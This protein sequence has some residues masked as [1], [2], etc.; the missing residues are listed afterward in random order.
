MK[1]ITDDAPRRRRAIAVALCAVAV[2]LT[3]VRWSTFVV[4]SLAIAPRNAVPLLQPVLQAWRSS[5]KV[6]LPP[7]PWQS[8]N[9]NHQ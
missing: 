5:V 8:K 1:T 6:T 3:S 7:S 2:G 9:G 4:A